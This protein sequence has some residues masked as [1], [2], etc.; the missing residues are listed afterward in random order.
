MRLL[1]PGGTSSKIYVWNAHTGEHIRTLSGHTSRVNSV[2]F[3]PDGNTIA[4]GSPDGTVLLWE[5]VPSPTSNVTLSLSPASLQSPTIGEQ[6]TFSLKIADA[7]NVAGY[8]ATVSYDTTA[9]RVHREC[10]RRLPTVRR[11]LYSTRSS[12]AIL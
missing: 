9:L 1:V 10:Q 8:Q 4:S 12:K 2:S 3:S 6:I 7:E 11:V 5:L